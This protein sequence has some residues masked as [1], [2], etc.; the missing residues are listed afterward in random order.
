MDHFE[1]WGSEPDWAFSV[2]FYPI[3][4]IFIGIY[5]IAE[6]AY[7]F[8]GLGLIGLSVAWYVFL[9]FALR[10]DKKKAPR[11]KPGG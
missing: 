10:E 1:P 2:V 8:W 3:V 7:P 11:P 4:V 6:T 5:L 9:G